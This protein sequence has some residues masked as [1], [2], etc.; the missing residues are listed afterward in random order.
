MC[1]CRTT[2][3][4]GSLCSSR[5]REIA[6]IDEHSVRAAAGLT[7]N[8]LVRW[9]VGRW[10][11]RHR[12]LGRH[13][14]HRWRSHSRQRAFPR[15]QHQR[16]DPRS[17]GADAERRRRR[18]PRR[19]DGLRLRLEPP[20]GQGGSGV[21]G[22]LQHHPGKTDE[23]RA[24]ARESLAF[25]KRTQPLDVPSAGCIFRIPDPAREHRARRRF[26]LPPAH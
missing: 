24:T 13:A 19:R 21:V 26:L 5:D 14:R 16:F 15:T 3:F 1:W 6:Q 10:P 8:G 22:D 9:T 18:S 17:P 2:A 12:S 23:L 7:I 20:A 25:R 4:A 11:G